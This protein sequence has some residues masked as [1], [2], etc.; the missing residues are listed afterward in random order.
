MAVADSTSID[1]I[2]LCK[3]TGSVILTI[4]DSLPWDQTH[5]KL[6]EEKLNAYLGFVESGEIYSVYPDAKGRRISISLVARF[7][8]NAD[9]ESFIEHARSVAAMYGAELVQISSGAGYA[10]DPA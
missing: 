8:P 10:D 9:A 1:A 6:L 2:G 4:L 7:R 5:L 3:D